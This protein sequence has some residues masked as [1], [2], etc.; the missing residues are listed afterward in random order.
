MSNGLRTRKLLVEIGA[1]YEDPTIDN[2]ILRRMP[3]GWRLNVDLDKKENAR[4]AIRV[5]AAIFLV[6]WFIA[7][8]IV[9]IKAC[10]A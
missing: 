3:P 1:Q 9:A 7:T 5:G 6:A 2:P 8:V 10:L 4:M